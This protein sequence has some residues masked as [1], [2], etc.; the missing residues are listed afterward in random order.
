MDAQAIKFEKLRL[1]RLA[2]H[3]IRQRQ[4]I[5]MTYYSPSLI[6][7]GFLCRQ[8]V[9]LILGYYHLILGYY[10]SRIGAKLMIKQGYFIVKSK[11]LDLI[12]KE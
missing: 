2:F 8:A 12:V 4:L 3:R 11:D 1:V 5:R 6:L 7:A 9:Q 10:H